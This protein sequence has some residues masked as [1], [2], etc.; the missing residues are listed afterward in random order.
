MYEIEIIHNKTEETKFIFGVSIADA[1]RR[2]EL[3]LQDW[4]VLFVDYVD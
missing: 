3:S 1:F 4:T 2:S